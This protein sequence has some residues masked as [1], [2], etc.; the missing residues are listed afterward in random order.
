VLWQP[1]LNSLD[2]RVIVL[3]L[4]SAILLFRFHWGIS[5]VLVLASVGGVAL[6]TMIA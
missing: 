2:W 3:A 1:E 6:S 4:L 5:R